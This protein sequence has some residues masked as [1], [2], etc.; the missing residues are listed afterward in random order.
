MNKIEVLLTLEN[1]RNSFLYGN[2]VTKV[3]PDT[4]WEKNANQIARFKR[5]DSSIIEIPLH[6]ICHILLTKTPEG[7]QLLI[8][9][10]ESSLMRSIMRESHEIVL[11]YCET[12]AQIQIYK[13][14]CWF[15]FFRIMRNTASHKDGGNLHIWPK[16]LKKKGI[17][18]V[19]WKTKKLDVS[20]EGNDLEFSIPDALDMWIELHEFVK[21]NLS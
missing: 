7:R 3:I 13:E 18:S 21:Q 10:F 17:T 12:T 14:Q 1:I 6:D 8:S 11:K 15:Q 2:L 4:V 5:S 20:M 16:D 19:H 9:E